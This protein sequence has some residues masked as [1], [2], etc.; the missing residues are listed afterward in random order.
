MA[1]TAKFII[2]FILSSLSSIFVLAQKGNSFAGVR[3]GLAFPMGEMASQYFDN[4]GYALLGKSIGA[5]AAYFITPKIGFGVD[6]SSNSFGYDA[7]SYA[8]D[9]LANT[10]EYISLDLL[11][12]TY[13]ITTYM[14]GVYYKVHISQKFYSTFKLMGGYFRTR[15][16][17]QFYGADIYMRGKT[18]YWKTSSFDSEFT[19]LTGASFEYKL[20]KRV[21]F[22]LQADFTYSEASFVFL[23]SGNTSYTNYLQMPVLRIQP[24][25]NIHF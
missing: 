8:A 4:G 20:D 16:P 15:T 7:V 9:Y 17:D 18:Y 22:L 5:E 6:F 2:I 13:K 19:F 25:I 11:S 12:G 24:G 21:S 3:F 1:D 14:G 10:P 23:T